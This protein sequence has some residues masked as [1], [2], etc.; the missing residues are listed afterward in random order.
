MAPDIVKRPGPDHAIEIAASDARL[1]ITFAGQIVA[2]TRAALVMRE[3]GYAPVHYVPISDIRPDLLETSAHTTYCPYKG[4]CSYY[5]LSHDN[6]R[7]ENALWY[8]D[9]PYPDVAQI[10]DHAAFYADK[11][12]LA[13]GPNAIN[14][15]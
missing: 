13:I 15:E 3:A 1:V 8:Y 14:P 6:R 9:A 10:K 5:T 7:A 2:D 11:V 12:D 4:H